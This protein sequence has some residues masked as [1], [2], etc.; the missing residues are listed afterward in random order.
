VERLDL[1]ADRG[2]R[3]ALLLRPTGPCPKSYP[4]AV[5]VPARQPLGEIA[6]ERE[7]AI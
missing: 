7:A 2:L 3:H 5:G 1:P 4:R 6:A